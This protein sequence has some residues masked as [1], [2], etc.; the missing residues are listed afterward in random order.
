MGAAARAG[1]KFILRSD[2]FS[3]GSLGASTAVVACV[4]TANSKTAVF[5]CFPETNYVF[6][7]PWA[8]GGVITHAERG[9]SPDCKGMPSEEAHKTRVMKALQAAKPVIFDESLPASAFKRNTS[10]A[11]QPPDVLQRPPRIRR[12][13]A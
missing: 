3:H 2:R 7:A 12:A 13:A 8:H 6:S 1:K 10:V 11:L 5:M 4:A 9:E